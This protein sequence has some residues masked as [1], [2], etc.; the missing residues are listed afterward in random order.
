MEINNTLKHLSRE[1][2]IKAEIIDTRKHI[3]DL[4]GE[5]EFL[6][7]REPHEVKYIASIKDTLNNLYQ[8]LEELNEI[9]IR[10]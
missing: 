2:Q 6:L 4:E 8:N 3:K 1:E 7:V 10:E 5:L 9:Y